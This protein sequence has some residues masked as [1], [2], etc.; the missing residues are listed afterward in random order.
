MNFLHCC[1]RMIKI[2]VVKENLYP[3]WRSILKQP[4]SSKKESKKCENDFC[5]LLDLMHRNSGCRFLLCKRNLSHFAVSVVPCRVGLSCDHKTYGFQNS[6]YEARCFYRSRLL[7]RSFLRNS[8]LHFGGSSRENRL[9][10][11]RTGIC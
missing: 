6:S 2:I 5:A 11:N 9:C 7:H 1:V 10:G 8:I 3:P 4:N